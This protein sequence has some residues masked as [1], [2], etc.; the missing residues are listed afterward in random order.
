M[1][2]D[3]ISLAD[4]EAEHM[5]EGVFILFQTVDDIVQTVVLLPNDL[6]RLIAHRAAE[7]PEEAKGMLAGS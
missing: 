5:G 3:R 6:E 4:G 2:Q 7:K 1:N